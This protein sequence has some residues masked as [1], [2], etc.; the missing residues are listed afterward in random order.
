MKT[1]SNIVVDDIIIL[2]QK[3]LTASGKEKSYKDLTM[4]DFIVRDRQKFF[5]CALV[6]F[7]EEKKGVTFEKVI[8]S[9]LYPSFDKYDKAKKHIYNVNSILVTPKEKPSIPCVTP[10]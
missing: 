4:D 10:K 5:S 8:R 6:L 2:E 7:V 9:N 1:I 3:D